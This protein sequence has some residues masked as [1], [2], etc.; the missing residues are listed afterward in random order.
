MII[1]FPSTHEALAFE[2]QAQAASISGRLIPVPQA[3]T[4]GCGWAWAAALDYRD[5]L[6]QWLT[7]EAVP[8]EKI[9]VLHD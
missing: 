6:E 4:A 7:T 3:I 5:V 9:F 1:T 8:Y 2:H